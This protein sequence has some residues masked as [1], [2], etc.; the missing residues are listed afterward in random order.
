[1]EVL[2][3]DVILSFDFNSFCGFLEDD[4]GA[5]VYGAI[6]RP[7]TVQVVL[8]ST[9]LKDLSELETSSLLKANDGKIS[10]WQLKRG[11]HVW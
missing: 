5:G 10:N 6:F 11:L 8:T 9:F 4:F 1:M 7:C 3:S 2:L